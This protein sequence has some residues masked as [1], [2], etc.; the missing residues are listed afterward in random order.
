MT[1]ALPRKADP[2]LAPVLAADRVW[3]G[4]TT[5][6]GGR[7]FVSFPAADGPGIQLA[8]AWPGD[9]FDP[10]PDAAW[11]GAAWGD[12]LDG[13]HPEGAFVRVNAV[14]VGP[15]GRLWVVDAGAP[16]IGQPTVPGGAR[17]IVIDLDT[18]QVARSYDLGPAIHERSYVD[19]VRFNGGVAYLTDAGVPG[20]IVLDLATGQPRRVLDGHPST[21][22]R[23]AMRADGRV[24]RGRDGSELRIHAD[25]LEVSPDGRYLY[26]QPASGPLARIETRW[27]DDPSVPADVL[28]DRVE[29]WL[30]TPTTGGTAIDDTGTIYLGDVERRRILT[31]TPAGQVDTLIADPRLVWADAMWLD[32]DGYLWIP[33]AQLNRTPELAGGKQS[34]DYPVWI[35]KL[36]IP[37]RQIPE[38][39]RP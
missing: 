19:D 20:L 9:R 25:Q 18:D 11:N 39:R 15:D 30:D 7:V 10:Y 28:G 26:F 16:G 6:G 2:R 3:N 37:E 1:A 31:I 35:Y 29:P 17:L 23:R 27:L 36:R 33:A 22:D 4:V 5:T 12:G 34:V 14:R 38:E 21:V 8:E 32:S 24:L 13:E